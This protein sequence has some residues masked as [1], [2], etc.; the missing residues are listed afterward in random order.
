MLNSGLLSP[1]FVLEKTLNYAK[2][3]P[4]LPLNS[5]EGFIRQIMGWREFIRAVYELKGSEERTRNFWGF[6]RKI[7]KSFYDG[8]TGIVP[9]DAV[10]KN[11]L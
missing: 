5:L 7:P 3:N 4:D 11:V 9:L 8:S 10:I 2:G 1:G 6:S